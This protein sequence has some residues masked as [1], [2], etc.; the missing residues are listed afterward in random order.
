MKSFRLLSIIAA[1]AL[2]PA[3]IAIAQKSKSTLNS[4][5]NQQFPDNSAGAITPLILRNVTRD[6]ISST[7]QYAA[8]DAQVGTTYTIQ[9]SDYGQLVTFSNI[10]P[11]AVSLPQPL[12]PFSTFN[13]YI[14][15]L[16]VGLVTVTPVGSTINGSATVTVP[17]NQSVWIVSDG[18]NYQIATGGGSGA[19][20]PGTAN[21]VA[22]Y[23][24]S[25]TGLSGNPN[26][27]ISGTNGPG[28]LTVGISG[29]VTGTIGLGNL[30][31]GTTILS[32]SAGVSPLLLL[33]SISTTMVGRDTTDT[34]TNKTYNTAPTTGNLFQVNGQQISVTTGANNT[35]VLDTTPTITRPSL[36]SPTIGAALASSINGNF[37]TT[38]TWTL[39]GNAGKTLNFSNSLTLSGTDSTTI[40]FPTVSLATPVNV[41]ALN[42]A[43]QLITGGANVTSLSQTVGN[44]TVDCGTR[45]QQFIANNGPFTITAPGVDG[46]CILKITNNASASSVTFSGFSIG[47]NTGDSLTTVNGFKFFVYINRIGGDST[48][49]IKALQ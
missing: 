11:V 30:S 36:I 33:P 31:G 42:L 9:A 10:N 29:V 2:I 1:L 8:V 6:M 32:P 27:T 25:T 40:S 28:R 12:G 24:Q 47:S 43:G 46:Y 49:S 38:G 44:I 39:S 22:F 16:G 7:Q 23:P 41:A 20:S 26:L 17:T 35:V 14:S 21:Q 37:L 34:F 19:V 45:P 15:N 48:F 4:E 18:T 5:I 13:V 3:G